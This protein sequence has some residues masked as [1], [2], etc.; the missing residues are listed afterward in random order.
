MALLMVQPFDA[1]LFAQQT[2]STASIRPIGIPDGIFDATVKCFLQ[3]TVM[4]LALGLQN[5]YFRVIAPG[6][7]SKKW[8]LKHLRRRRLVLPGK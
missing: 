3:D 5:Q 1:A 7:S 8:I 4:K 2:A 6:P